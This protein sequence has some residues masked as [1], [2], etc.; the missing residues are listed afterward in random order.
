MKNSAVLSKKNSKEKKME[1]KRRNEVEP[2]GTTVPAARSIARPRIHI[3]SRR[4]RR[5]RALLPH[6]RRQHN[7]RQ[8]QRRLDNRV[9]LV[10]LLALEHLLDLLQVERLVLHQRLGQHVQFLP[11]LLQQRRRARLALFHE[12]DDFLFDLELGFRGE[13]LVVGVKVHVATDMPSLV[14][15]S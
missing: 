3:P 15:I 1:K 14:T 10:Q 13:V 11:L 4:R 5:R 8:L 2:D 9:H 7:L 6:P 12:A